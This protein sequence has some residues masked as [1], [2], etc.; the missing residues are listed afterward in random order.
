[1]FCNFSKTV[2]LTEEQVFRH[3]GLLEPYI[4]KPQHHINPKVYL[5]CKWYVFHNEMERAY[6]IS[7]IE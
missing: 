3:P 7:D 2:P 1:M 6:N 4:L 5:G